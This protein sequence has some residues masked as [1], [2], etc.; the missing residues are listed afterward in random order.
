MRAAGIKMQSHR[1]LTFL[2]SNPQR[3]PFLSTILPDRFP[4]APPAPIARAPSF[5][6][7]RTRLRN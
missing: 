7:R 4:R 5:I 6:R 3:R 2:R 1:R